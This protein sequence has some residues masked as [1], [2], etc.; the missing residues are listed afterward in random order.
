[1]KVEPLPHTERPAS[2]ST[3][4]SAI[5]ALIAAAMVSSINLGAANIALVGIAVELDATESDLTRIGA[6]ST[7]GMACCILYF[8][9]L[10]QSLG[11]S[12][13]IRLGVSLSI[14]LSFAAAF[15]P[16]AGWLVA[17][18]LAIGMA[19][20]MIYPNT[21]A[22]IA[23][24]T[25]GPRR[26]G[27]IG[28]WFGCSIGAAA[29]GPVAAGLLMMQFWWGVTFLVSVPIAALSLALS[30][31]LPQHAGEDHAPV[32]HLGGFLL[33]IGVLLFVGVLSLGGA[34]VPTVAVLA[35]LGVSL[36]AIA[37][38][39]VRQF[40]TAHPLFDFRVAARP[41]FWTA[42]VAGSVIVGTMLGAFFLGQQFLQHILGYSTAVAGL[43]VL[44]SGL[45]IVL[46][47]PRATRLGARLGGRTMLLTGTALAALG[48][49]VMLLWG[50]DRGYLPVSVTY[51]L[52]GV[53]VGVVGAT[54]SR[55]LMASVS[56]AEVSMGAATSDLQSCL[57]GAI[58]ITLLGSIA[59][60]A[61][62]HGFDAGFAVSAPGEL[63][64]LS[65]DQLAAARR[66]LAGAEHISRT[67][68]TVTADRL[69]ETSNRAFIHAV[70][71]AVLAGVLLLAATAVLLAVVF[72][73]RDR[74]RALQEIYSGG[75]A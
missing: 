72:P 23:A 38:A 24:T 9:R 13:M 45:A 33:C 40:R 69:L 18:R 8:G 74:E 26:N 34:A 14:P 48:M 29:L 17:A 11:R 1:M 53:G 4:T 60:A 22:A 20:A 32:D 70:R 42:A 75:R 16:S 21:L 3:A 37:A 61:Y 63:A 54:V 15:A 12:R 7:L 55:T 71:W 59:A 43:A 35:G 41:T 73:G 57:G 27:A 44:P 52:L 66:S 5:V 67:L 62:Q 68:D 30:R 19:G 65:A 31:Q 46:T 36:A 10:S 39:V 58:L 64:E 25:S 6:A 50:P 47:S 28:L 49:L 51:L 2:S 56:G